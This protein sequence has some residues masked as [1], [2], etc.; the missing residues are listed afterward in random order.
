[1]SGKFELEDIE[2][3]PDVN[4]DSE[5]VQLENTDNEATDLKQ[6]FDIDDVS[7]TAPLP[8]RKANTTSLIA[9]LFSYIFTIARAIICD[10]DCSQ[11][12]IH[13]SCGQFK[14]PNYSLVCIIRNHVYDAGIDYRLPF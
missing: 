1:M 12:I 10:D 9:S 11:F 14:N 3:V 6:S 5:N 2:I 7:T 4:N 13:N 8:S